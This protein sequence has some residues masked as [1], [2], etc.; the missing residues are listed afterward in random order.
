[1]LLF[2]LRLHG[3]LLSLFFFFLAVGEEVLV[4]TPL[5]LLC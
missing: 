1:M 4:S 5:A 3:S 2:L